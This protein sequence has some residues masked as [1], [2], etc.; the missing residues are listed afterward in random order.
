MLG[1]EGRMPRVHMHSGVSLGHASPL[2]RALVGGFREPGCPRER[3]APVGC[4]ALPDCEA[5][6]IGN[7]FVVVLVSTRA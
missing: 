2:L 6:A 4:R 3:L 7:P 5:I 1:A